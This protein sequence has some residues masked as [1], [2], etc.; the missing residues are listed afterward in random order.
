M[1]LKLAI[2]TASVFMSAGTALAHADNS[3]SKNYQAAKK[4]IQLVFPSSTS[5]IMLKVAGC[6]TG[7]IY[8][9]DAHNRSGA[10][11]YFQILSGHDGETYKYDGISVTVD[12]NR[13][14]E[15][16][17]NSLVAYCMSKGGT[18]LSPWNQS[19]GCW[20]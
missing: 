3:I 5:D 7:G 6:E 13:L 1:F 19:K 10:S 20:A 8:N 18:S 16:M 15:P 9:P 4:T 2:L 17:Y 12:K 11:G 14:F